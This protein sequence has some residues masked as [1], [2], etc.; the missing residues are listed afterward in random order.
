MVSLGYVGGYLCVVP[1]LE[2]FPSTHLQST[3]PMNHTP[4]LTCSMKLDSNQV[5]VHQ[6]RQSSIA[7]SATRSAKQRGAEALIPTLCARHHTG[8]KVTRAGTFRNLIATRLLLVTGLVVRIWLRAAFGTDAASG[9]LVE[10]KAE[11]MARRITRGAFSHGI[12]CHLDRR[13]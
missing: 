3:L 9:D 11:R 6:G 10:A 4:E 8:V 7:L 1:R 5:S 12:R 2:T 13:V